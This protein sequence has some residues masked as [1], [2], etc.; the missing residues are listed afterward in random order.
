MAIVY[1]SEQL[2]REKYGVILY[3]SSC[4]GKSTIA[5]YMN[6]IFECHLLHQNTGGFQDEME[7]EDT[8]K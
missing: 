7:R 4:S 6:S 2:K 3:G 5:K 8:N 1:L